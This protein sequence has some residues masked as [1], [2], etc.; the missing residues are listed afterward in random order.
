MTL[1]P[2]E[3]DAVAGWKRRI[4]QI[5]GWTVD[6]SADYSVIWDS[7]FSGDDFAQALPNGGEYHTEMTLVA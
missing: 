7:I 6:K 3:L 4:S 2:M 5:Q 1:P